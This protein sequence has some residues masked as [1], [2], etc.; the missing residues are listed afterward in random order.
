MEKV[1]PLLFIAL[2]LAVI[3]L[4]LVSMWKIY[5]KAGREGWEAIIPYYNYYV[6]IVNICGMPPIYFWLLLV[7]CANVVVALILIFMIPI[8]LAEK[9]GKETGFA[10]G[11]IFLAP[12]FYPMLA[13]GDAEYEGG[14][15]SRYDDDDDDDD[16]DDRPRKK[17]AR[18]EDDD[19]E[20]D[21][22]P[23]KK[24]PRDEDEDEDDDRPRKKKR[25]D[26]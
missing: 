11:L 24:T 19:E 10:I 13:F 7:P 14:R 21:D 22:R 4:M 2:Y 1:F 5:V 6:M 25:D 26:W 12:I 17:K 9:F 23:P 16:Y 18:A 20:E 15:R 8:K 3:V